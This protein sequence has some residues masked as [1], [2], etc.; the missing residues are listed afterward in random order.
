MNIILGTI[1]GGN[2][3]EYKLFF[4]SMDLVDSPETCPII[5]VDDM[6]G[7]P[8]PGVLFIPFKRSDRIHP[9]CQR[10]MLYFEFLKMNRMADRVLLTDCRDVY[11]LG[12]PFFPS[13]PNGLHVFLED[14]RMDI[15]SCQFNREWVKRVWGSANAERLSNKPISCAGVTIGDYQSM[16]EYL[17]SMAWNCD[18]LVNALV[19]VDQGIHNG[20]VYLDKLNNCII[21]DNDSGPVLTMG[22]MQ[23]PSPSKL[24]KYAIIHQYDRHPEFKAYLEKL[25]EH[26]RNGG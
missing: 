20:L 9:N 26:S 3:D 14:N 24:G 18:D 10:F 6:K 8:P 23:N 22:Y 21:H 25:H 11:F 7:I 1:W 12:D 17:E 16:I 13:L 4:E 15:G 2:F 19:N 5:F